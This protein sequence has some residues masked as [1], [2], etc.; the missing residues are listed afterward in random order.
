MSPSAF[1]EGNRL[2]VEFKGALSENYVLQALIRQFEA[3]PRYWAIDNP[4][5]EIDFLIQRE[6]DFIPVEVKSETNVDSK[7]LKK[8][9]EKYKDK[10]K[11]RVRFSLNN[12]K[13]D[14][15][16]LN[17]PLFMADYADKLIG[18]ALKSKYY[19]KG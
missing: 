9:K 16:V 1:A 8:F 5:Y 3:V 15:D 11:I 2:F 14:D 12:L 7:S 4:H 10:V 6:N 17:I 18:I 13:M 19:S